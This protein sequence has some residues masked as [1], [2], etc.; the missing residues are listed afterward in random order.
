[1]PPPPRTCFIRVRRFELESLAQS[2]QA[3]LAASFCAGSGTACGDHADVAQRSD[4]ER[5]IGVV[6]EHRQPT[7]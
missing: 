7:T 2:S 6:V 5:V 4:D 3:L 1:M